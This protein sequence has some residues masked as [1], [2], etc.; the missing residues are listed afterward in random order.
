M[1]LSSPVL[2]LRLTKSEEYV[3][4]GDKDIHQQGAAETAQQLRVL[5]LKDQG[6][7]PSTT[8]W[9]TPIRNSGSRGPDTASLSIHTLYTWGLHVQICKCMHIGN[10]IL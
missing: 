6:L 10:T 2:Y 3:L 9:L 5:A 7:L 8:C 4:Q 1:V